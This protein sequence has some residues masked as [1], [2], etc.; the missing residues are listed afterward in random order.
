MKLP[1]FDKVL[2]CNKEE[3]GLAA[4]GTS[5]A[6]S[7]EER[8]WFLNGREELADF[9]ASYGSRTY[10]GGL[11]RTHS[12]DSAIKWTRLL[13]EYYPGFKDKIRTFGYDWEGN[14]MV[15]RM[16]GK[17]SVVMIFECAT[18]DYFELE[19]TI[20][21]FHEEDLVAYREDTLHEEKYRLATSFL[22]IA[23]IPG[24]KCIA[25]KT[26]LLLGGED[27]VE[28]MEVTDLEVIWSLQQQIIDKINKMP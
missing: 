4:T 16:E 20:K 15:Q 3:G 13:K 23:G 11:Y 10:N 27:L 8:E 1:G 17:E 25:H 18:G 7:A 5:G 14:M 22:G 2:E 28:N 9:L 6:V 21:G 12:L 26:S 19:Q 24:E